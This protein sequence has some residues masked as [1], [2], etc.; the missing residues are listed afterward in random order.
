MIDANNNINTIIWNDALKKL[1]NDMN[2]PTFDT[3]FKATELAAYYGENIII[4]VQ[5]DFAKNMLQN[6]Y[7][8]V[9]KNHL[10]S[11]L[12]HPVKIRFVTPQEKDQAIDCLLY[13]SSSPTPT[14]IK[15]A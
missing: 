14:A 5:N 4:K 8:N 12:N 1:E 2:K 3:W 9:I 15:S 13:T 6:T 7:F 10:E 11:M